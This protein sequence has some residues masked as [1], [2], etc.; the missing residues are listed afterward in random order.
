MESFEGE[1][2]HTT[3]WRHDVDL[4]GMRVGVLGNGS[5]GT[6]F[7]PAISKDPTVI[8]INFARTARYYMPTPFFRYS[9]TTKWAFAHIPLAQFIH[10]LK[11]AAKSE[12]RFPLF[13]KKGN[14]RLGKSYADSSKNYMKGIVPA[15]YHHLIIPTYPIGCKRIVRDRG[16]LESLNRPN[17]RLTFDHI[18][19]VEPDG[20]IMA[21]G[22]KVPLD[23]I[24]CGTGFIADNYP[25][26]LRGT[27]STL[28]EYN[29]AHGGP[30]AYL[31][32]TVPGFPN[33]FMM[34]GP[35]T[36]TGHTSIIAS[37]ELQATYLLQL[38]EPVRTGVLT[39]IAPTD[40]ATDKYNAT[41]QEKLKDFVWSQ[42]ASWYRAGADGRGRVIHLFPGPFVLLW[43]WLRRVRWEDYEVKGPGAEEWRRRQA[44]GRWLRRSGQLVT[45]VLVGALALALHFKSRVR[46]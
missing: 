11:I 33:L 43:W 6:Q 14:N 5:S 20:V 18:A 30:M 3:R 21:T 24:I 42:C 26:N 25:F 44:R 28:K 2:F 9:E 13:R 16:Y 1:V 4:H 39:S 17:V 38:L 7:I 29:D 41:L 22:E 40:A 31:G 37:E 35:N 32:S 8:V 27:R 34:Q 46:S 19:S 10:R 15:R 12:I 45:A 36:A 23:V